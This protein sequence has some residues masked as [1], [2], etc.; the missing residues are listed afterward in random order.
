MERRGK[1]K[2]VTMPKDRSKQQRIEEN[3]N[4]HGGGALRLMFGVWDY[5]LV[6]RSRGSYEE[7]PGPA[8][9]AGGG[10]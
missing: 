7:A 10:V 4:G 1:L 8:V 6:S 5:T 9:E 3:N 2:K